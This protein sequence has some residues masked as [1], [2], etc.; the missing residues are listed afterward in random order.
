MTSKLSQK[1]WLTFLDGIR[2]FSALWVLAGHCAYRAGWAPSLLGTP[3][4]AVDIFIIIS[5][6]LMSYHYGEVGDR[7]S[8]KSL[9]TWRVFYI[10]RFFRIAP[11]YYFLLIPGFSL[12]QYLYSWRQFTETIFPLPWATHY[13]NVGALNILLHVS[14]LFGLF[15]QY[16]SSTVLPDWSIGLEMQFYVVF[17]FIML[18]FKRFS[19][20]WISLLLCSISVFSNKLLYAHGAVF[21]QPSFLLLKLDLFIMGILLASATYYRLINPSL[22]RYLV[23][24]AIVIA[25]SKGV[26]I[27]T[28]YIAMSALL[29][30]EKEKD[31]LRINKIIYLVQ[32][33]LSN[34]ISTFMAKVSYSVYLVHLLILTPVGALLAHVEWYVNLPG[35]A[36]FSIIFILV[37]FLTYCIAYPLY[38]Y[39]EQPGVNLGKNLIKIG[40]KSLDRNRAL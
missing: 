14:F 30:Y 34:K 2:G 5:G 11:L 31:L 20:F 19:Y 25:A 37:S 32:F 9:Q 29:F 28:L 24:I 6:F 22:Q 33:N 12:H 17:P 16:S 10:R 8:W 13:S 15:P 36:R 3:G 1:D 40:E 18:L 27:A 4:L 35:F 23:V 39:V 7:N 26:A 38:R 21:P